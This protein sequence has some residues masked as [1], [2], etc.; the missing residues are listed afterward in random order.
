MK[1]DGNFKELMTVDIESLVSRVEKMTTEEWLEDT[2]RQ[3]TFPLIYD[4]ET[5][6]LCFN[7]YHDSAPSETTIYPNWNK[8]EDVIQ[9]V[10]DQVCP[11]FENPFLN[12]C[13]IV[14]LKAKGEIAAHVDEPSNYFSHRLHIPLMTNPDC[15]M[16][17]GDEPKNMKKGVLYK[18]NNERV[19]SVVNK[20]NSDRI[21]LMFDIYE[22]I[23]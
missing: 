19:H 20:G 16:T 12:K 22:K 7:E 9:P 15:I 1:F 6:I 23:S 13:A 8:W 5:V 10:L 2:Y 17:T 14:K 18:V 4:T 3:K 11:L 21:H